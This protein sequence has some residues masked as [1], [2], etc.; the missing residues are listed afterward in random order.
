MA[1]TADSWSKHGKAITLIA[2][3]FAVSVNT[4]GI[5]A[6]SVTWRIGATGEVLTEEAAV[7]VL[8]SAAPWKLPGFG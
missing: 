3:A 6:R 5:S 4:D 2:D 8:A 1:L 7:I